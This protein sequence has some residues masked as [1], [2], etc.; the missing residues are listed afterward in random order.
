MTNKI[1]EDYSLSMTMTC[2][3]CG[4]DRISKGHRYSNIQWPDIDVFNKLEIIFCNSCGFGFSWPEIIDSEVENFYVND[5]RRESSPFHIDFD[6]LAKPSRIDVRALSQI[7][8]AKQFTSFKDGDSFIDIGPGVGGSFNAANLTLTNPDCSAIEL[9]N[10]AASAF[11]NIYGIKT[12]P[13][14]KD[15]L[16]GGKKAQICLLSHSL[17]HYKVS[18]LTES[19]EQFKFL[20]GKDG[21]LVVEVPLVDMRQ[22]S[23]LREDDSPHFLFFSID[24]IKILFEKSGWDVLFCDSVAEI[25]GHGR[26][27]KSSKPASQQPKQSFKRLAKRILKQTFSIL[28]ETLKNLVRRIA[29]RDA[30]D[31]SGAQF[32]YGGDRT[33]LRLV[34]TP[35]H[36]N[37]EHASI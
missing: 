17:E 36:K 15:F 16:A 19:L 26:N 14:V 29:K 12:Y 30:I 8:L 2:P 25:Y 11:E 3:V 20:L 6:R 31:F 28:P 10:G 5:Y 35:N 33:C 22:H 24:S 37:I 13:T 4:S 21:V 7:L 18:W 9:N 27:S 32:S 34:A 23:E 1:N